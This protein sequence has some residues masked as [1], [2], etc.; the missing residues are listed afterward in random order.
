MK[1]LRRGHSAQHRGPQ[2]GKVGEDVEDEQGNCQ[3]LK[4]Q[5]NGGRRQAEYAIGG[6][7]REVLETLLVGGD[8]FDDAVAGELQPERFVYPVD[9]R[10][11]VVGGALGQFDDLADC[12]IDQGI[13]EE[14]RKRG[15]NLERALTTPIKKLSDKIC[16]NGRE[17]SSIVEA[18]QYFQLKP[19]TV[20]YRLAKG[21]KIEE[22]FGIENNIRRP[23]VNEIEFDG[24]TYPN[25]SE[26]ARA[27]GVRPG[28]VRERL[29]YGWS[30]K[31]SLVKP[32]K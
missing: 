27:Y 30:L 26:L 20:R 22:A 4:D 23:K 15:W 24:N 28:L 16:V 1:L 10:F 14:R 7:G 6:V 9:G 25:I 17:F 31:E 3:Q 29:K 21:W 2:S 18:A 11:H 5:S 8:V 32:K 13:R 19:S 12:H